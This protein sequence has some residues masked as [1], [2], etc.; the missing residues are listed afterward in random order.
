MKFKS[1][2]LKYLK[3]LLQ[4]TYVRTF[5]FHVM[6]YKCNTFII[7]WKVLNNAVN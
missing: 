7:K 4:W 3:M 6:K 1:S 2:S 5:C